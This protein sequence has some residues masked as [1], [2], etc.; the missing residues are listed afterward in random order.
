[1]RNRNLRSANINLDAIEHNVRFIK[2]KTGG[3]VITVVKAN[4]YG[5]GAEQVA[6]AALDA[7][8]TMLGVADLSEAYELRAAG[9]GA[10]ILCWI[11]GPDSDFNRAV[12][13]NLTLAIAFRSQLDRLADV[14]ASEGTC[15]EIHL[16][17]DTGLSR[18]GAAPQEWEE[19]FQRAAD[20]EQQGHI[21]VQGV[22][23]HLSNTSHEEDLAQQREFD[24]AITLLAD[25]GIDPQFKHIASSA[26]TL[27]SPHLYYNTVRVGLLTYGLSPFEDQ[28]SEQIGIRPAMRL[29]AQVAAVRNVSEGAGVSYNYHYRVPRNT[30]LALVPV[31]YADGLRR[32]LSDA[33]ADALIRGVRCPIVGRV[34]MDQVLV[35]LEPL[36]EEANEVELGE[37]VVLFGDPSRGEPAMDEWANLAHTINYEIATGIG[38]RVAR[39]YHR[40]A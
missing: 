10:P 34:S 7:G 17:L 4:G 24:T 13:E 9:I 31:G 36:K 37:P 23:T 16:K 25:T 39:V 11:H 12:R 1:M 2:E 19:L 3:E 33:G 20:L 27:T 21:R 28:T 30:R 5:H 15:A 8:A 40:D 26:A 35:N 18:N 38:P 22:F 32:A 29:E 6:R 14:A